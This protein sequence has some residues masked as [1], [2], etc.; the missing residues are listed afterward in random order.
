MGKSRQQGLYVDEMKIK[1]KMSLAFKNRPLSTGA[2]KA[3][4]GE[5]PS[6]S[7][8][9]TTKMGTF[10]RSRET[11]RRQPMRSVDVETAKRQREQK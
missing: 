5:P 7:V 4:G 10:L 11:E 1:L 6:P 3:V 9:K 2:G 8:P